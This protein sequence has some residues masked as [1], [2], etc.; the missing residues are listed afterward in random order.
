MDPDPAIFDIDLQDANKK[1]FEGTF[2]SLFKDKKS[3]KSQNIWNQGF[4]CYF[5]LMIEG[6][7]SGREPVADPYL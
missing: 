5:C 1:L 2:T 6:P 3:T 7:G 4:S